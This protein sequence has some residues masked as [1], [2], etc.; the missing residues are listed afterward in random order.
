VIGRTNKHRSAPVLFA[1]LALASACGDAQPSAGSPAS[2]P[3]TDATAPVGFPA[4]PVTRAAPADSPLTEARAQLGRRLF[5]DKNLSRTGL[6]ACASCH[7]PELAFADKVAVSPGVD[8]RLG[9]R[10]A[11]SLANLAWNDR[12]FLDGRAAS[13][14]EQAG[15]PIENPVEMDLPRAEA[16]ARLAAD[17]SYVQAF[18]GAFGQPPSDLT[19]RQALASFV[20]TLVSGDSPY[21]RHLRGDDSSFPAEAQRGETVFFGE[22]GGCFHCHAPGALTN[23]GFFNNGSYTDGGDPGREGVTGLPGDLGKFKVPGLRNVAV[24]APYMHDGSLLT[25]DAV[26]WQYVQ[27]GRDHTNIDPQI[28]QLDLCDEDVYDLVAFLNALTDDAFLNDSR[29]RP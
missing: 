2:R 11:P 24:T 12:F 19:M 25:L 6:V 18:A 17:D 21:D 5:F 7:K 28:R 22:R 13:L 10:N 9:N 4:G 27:A 1:A 14:E 15:M 26:C 23:D 20:R 3:L 16:V 8:G 29:Y